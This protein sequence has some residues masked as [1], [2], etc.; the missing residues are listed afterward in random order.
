MSKT[1]G[2][3]GEA[4]KLKTGVRR[5]KAESSKLKAQS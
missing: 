2:E 4:K 1:K 5:Q 3:R